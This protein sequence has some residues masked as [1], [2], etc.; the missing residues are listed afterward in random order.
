M[1]Q[2]NIKTAEVAIIKEKSPQ[3]AI[4]EGIEKIGGISKYISADDQ[5]FI[6]LNL[7]LPNGFPVNSNFNVL[8]I[9]IELCKQVGAE[10]IYVG[11]FANEEIAQGTLF[12]MLDLNKYIDSLGAELINLDDFKNVPLATIELNNKLFKFPQ[13]IL[14]SDKIISINQVSVDPLFKCSL[15]LVNS[16]SMVPN[17]YQKIQKFGR[18]GK[19]YLPLDQYKK[20]LIANILDVFTI[21]VPNLVIN[22]LYYLMEGAGP[23][24]YKD[25]EINKT[26]LMVIGN[27][28]V[29]VDYITLK[30]LNLDPMKEGLIIECQSR[31]IGITNLSNINITGE[32]LEELSLEIKFCVYKLEDIN[33]LNTAIKTGKHCSGCYKQAYHLLNLIKTHMVKDLKYLRKQS[34]LVGESPQ[35]PD[36]SENVILFGDCA[37]NSTKDMNFRKIIIN[38]DMS[39][40]EKINKKIKK[41]KK[42]ISKKKVKEKP[43]KQILEL[44][45]CPP[46]IPNCIESLIKYYS[47][48][49]VPNLNFYNQLI[50]TYLIQKNEEG[51]EI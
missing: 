49:T 43:N 11:S 40:L 35:A 30:I 7:R 8:K 21:K 38:E 10:K 46:D 16:Y 6:K 12:H 51:R 22:D 33:I 2:K 24:I 45:G 20:D 34:I 47:K 29:A 13:I 37:I 3:E 50:E 39:L 25:S 31:D 23:Y 32:N 44:S 14:D 1:D 15:S 28:A 48:S 27:N 5:V 36:Y 19:Y 4:L 17:R 41:N 9:L 26:Q 42:K 18:S